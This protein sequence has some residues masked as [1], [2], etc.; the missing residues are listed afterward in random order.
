MARGRSKK[1]AECE[2]LV[3]QALEGISKKKWKSPAQAAKAL[4]ICR[5]TIARRLKGGKSIAQSREAAQLLIIPEEKALVGWITRLTMTGHPATH[6]FIRELAEEIREHRV[7]QINDEMELVSYPSIGVSWVQTFLKRHSQL[8]TTLS[9]A[10]EASRITTIRKAAMRKFFD[11]YQNVLAEEGINE[12][13]T[14]NMDET[15]LFLGIKTDYRLCN[16]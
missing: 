12:E 15:G 16:W 13:H 4:G 10:I 5:H 14:Y 6:A 3:L 8:E 7:G 9:H 11:D 2:S 1:R